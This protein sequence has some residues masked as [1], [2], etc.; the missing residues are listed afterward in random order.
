MSSRRL[1]Q[2]EVNRSKRINLTQAETP[3]YDELP[4]Y[5]SILKHFL[6]HFDSAISI[7]LCS[8]YHI[9]CDLTVTPPHM[10]ESNRRE[11][12]WG[13]SDPHLA[14]SKK[15]ALSIKLQGHPILKGGVAS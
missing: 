13:D 4:P 9:L 7:H 6:E 14:L 15:A 5:F 8:P 1:K 10:I 12:P 3:N 2:R 11:C